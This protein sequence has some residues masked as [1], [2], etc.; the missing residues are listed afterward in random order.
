MGTRGTNLLCTQTQSS[1]SGRS[2]PPSVASSGRCYCSLGS[3]VYLAGQGERK[4]TMLRGFGLK[5]LARNL[6]TGCDSSHRSA[7]LEPSKDST[8]MMVYFVETC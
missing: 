5:S 8:R 4:R 7:G 1:G 6:E 3:A 2:A